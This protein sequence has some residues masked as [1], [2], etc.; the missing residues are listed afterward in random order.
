VAKGGGDMSG[1]IE[2][3][4]GR[5]MLLD[6]FGWMETGFPTTVHAGPGTHGI[7]VEEHLADGNYVLWAELPAT[8]PTMSR[9]P[10]QKTF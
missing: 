8:S 4:P 3:L 10:S 7:R 1:M 6:L 2:R 5:P 9:S